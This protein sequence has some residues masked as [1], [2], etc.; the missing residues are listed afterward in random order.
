VQPGLLLVL[1]FLAGVTILIGLPLGRLSSLSSTLRAGLSMLATGIL[2]FLF[3]EILGDAMEEATDAFGGGGPGVLAGVLRAVLVAAGFAAGFLGLIAFEKKLIP[4]AA[5]AGP[6]RLS[7]MI[8]AGIGLHNLSE[9]LAIGQSAAR[10]MRGLT[11]TLVLGF[12]LHNAT[13]G[14][15]IVGPMVR[16]GRPVAWPTILLLALIGG[17]PTFAG[18]LLGSLWK[19]ELLSS[20]VLGLAGGALL[21]I[22]RELFGAVKKEPRQVLV[23]L[24][25]VA[26][27][28]LGWGTG[29]LADRGLAGSVG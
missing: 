5:E 7:F 29:I 28:V 12:A 4:G 25:L 18:T 27:F 14:F 15:G 26:G 6:R 20:A 16:Q 13:E 2:V 21:Y 19:S 1:G 10:G 23:M 17:G 9:G 3:V 24:G 22:I 8:A 11:L